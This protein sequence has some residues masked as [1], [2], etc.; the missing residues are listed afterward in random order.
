MMTP[1]RIY[2]GATVGV[3]GTFTG[4]GG[5]NTDPATVTCTTLAPSGKKVAYTYGT[6]AELTKVST[7]RFKL[8]FAPN[9]AGR[10]FV[11]WVST[12]PAAVEEDDFIVTDSPF[13]ITPRVDY[14]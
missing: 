6:S 14:V 9:E 12:T 11:R 8:T 7:G 10:W 1:G 13:I 3:Y 4:D 5:G 2:P